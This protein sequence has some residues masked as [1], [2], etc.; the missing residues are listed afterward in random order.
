MMD[1][2]CRRV[3]NHSLSEQGID[4]ISVD[5]KSFKRYLEIAKVLKMRVAVITDNDGNYDENITAAYQGYMDNEFD[6]IKIYSELDNERYTFEVAIYRDNQTACDEL[7]ESGRRTLSI[8]N[9]MLANKAEAAF[10]L[11]TEKSDT[12]VT[13]QYIK[14][15]LEWVSAS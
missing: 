11:L 13:P 12:I 14:N 4:V 2:F 7:F 6:N 1:V 3:L 5:G 9:Y 10:K 8:L 15:A